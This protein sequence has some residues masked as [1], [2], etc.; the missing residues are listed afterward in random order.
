MP[1][2]R[3]RGIGDLTDLSD[4]LN[5]RKISDER[6]DIPETSPKLPET[7]PK[8]AEK[9]VVV[10]ETDGNV[11]E[12]MPIVPRSMDQV[13]YE[14]SET[15]VHDLEDFNDEIGADEDD[16][17]ETVDGLVEAFLRSEEAKPFSW[18]QDEDPAF[19]KDDLREREYFQIVD[20]YVEDLL[21][22][23]PQKY[24]KFAIIIQGFM[25]T[26]RFLA[27]APWWVYDYGNLI[28]WNIEKYIRLKVIP[29]W[30]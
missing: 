22:E 5:N 19:S 13:E 14:K 2:I 17:P 11:P 7:S 1:I 29:R 24:L 4:L 16:E 9:V 23:N 10:P 12:N 6:P 26:E 28:L 8:P 30:N 3:T 25:D 21:M 18:E 15:Y 20:N 27:R